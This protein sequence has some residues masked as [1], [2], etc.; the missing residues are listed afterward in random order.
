MILGINT[1]LSIQF[2]R[3]RF[4]NPQ[5]FTITYSSSIVWV[6]KIVIV[7]DIK[8]YKYNF[9]LFIRFILVELSL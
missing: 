3:F 8:L 2:D 9:H 1:R 5:Y 4:R 7:A 6:N